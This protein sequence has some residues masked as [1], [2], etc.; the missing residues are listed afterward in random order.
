MPCP[1]LPCT[2]AGMGLY[3]FLGLLMDALALAA[4]GI[5]LRIAPHFDRPYRS[6]SVGGWVHGQ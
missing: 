5:G 4:T 3:C 6:T 2:A 1:A